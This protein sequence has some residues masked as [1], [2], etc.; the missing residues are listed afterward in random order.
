MTRIGL[1]RCLARLRIAAEGLC[2]LALMGCVGATRLL[3]HTNGP[4]GTTIQN[5]DIDMSFLKAGTTHREEVDGRLNRIDTHYSNSRL[6]WG[7][8]SGSKW[9]AWLIIALPGGAGVAA[10]RF[11]H[12]N[13]LLVIFDENGVMQKDEL[14]DNEKVLERELRAQLLK[15]P[16]LDLSQPVPFELTVPVGY[17]GQP[18]GLPRN[19]LDDIKL[20]KEFLFLSGNNFLLQAVKVSPLKVARISYEHVYNEKSS[21]GTICHN[22]H[23][24]EKTPIGNKLLL[25]TS[26][27]NLATMFQYF[28]Q[29]GST[30]LRWE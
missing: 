2:A 18:R 15:A 13:N 22:L 28:Q 17:G 7:R 14:I 21:S 1:G 4:E 11:W 12:V 5:D 20:T 26:A 6:F 3:T 16:P 8:W 19:F 27:A 9:G 10:G 24:S 23:V 30:N 29:A 25:C